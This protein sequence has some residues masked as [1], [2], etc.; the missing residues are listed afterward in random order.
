MALMVEDLAACRAPVRCHRSAV[1]YYIVKHS[2]EKFIQDIR[3]ELL[4]DTICDLFCYVD[5][6]V[7]LTW[8]MLYTRADN[9]SCSFTRLPD[10]A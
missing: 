1:Q 8:S 9:Q 10:I 7:C 6:I 2:M 3:T 4:Q 5:A